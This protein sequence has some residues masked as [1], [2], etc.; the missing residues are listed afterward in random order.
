[1]AIVSFP[2]LYADEWLKSIE[3]PNFPV[4]TPSNA[5]AF[6]KFGIAR[7]FIAVLWF[8]ISGR[9]SVADMMIFH[10]CTVCGIVEGY[11]Q[12]HQIR[13]NGQ[14]GMSKVYWINI[15][16]LIVPQVISMFFNAKMKPVNVFFYFG[17][18]GA[19]TA[20]SWWLFKQWEFKKTDTSK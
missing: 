13:I 8:F 10:F 15:V 1:M 6:M 5:N 14:Y 4:W 19:L 12:I 2:P 17:M 11:Q 9:I 16:Q 20:S 18:G 3:S 7:F